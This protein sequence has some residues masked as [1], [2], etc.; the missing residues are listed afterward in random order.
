MPNDPEQFSA[1]EVVMK[2]KNCGHP[3]IQSEIDENDGKCPNCN[4]KFQ[5]PDES[6]S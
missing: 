2:C 3:T 5:T 1:T 6:S 4:E